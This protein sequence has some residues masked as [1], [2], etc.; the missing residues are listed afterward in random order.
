MALGS[1]KSSVAGPKSSPC[2][3]SVAGLELIRQLGRGEEAMRFRS[4]RKGESKRG[5]IIAIVGRISG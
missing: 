4:L 1:G 2:V 3:K 5:Y